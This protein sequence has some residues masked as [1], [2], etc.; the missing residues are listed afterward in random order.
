M[1]TSLNVLWDGE[2]G[3]TGLRGCD[4]RRQAEVEAMRRDKRTAVLLVD[5]LVAEVAALRAERAAA[6]AA[7]AAATAAAVAA[8][9]AGAGVGADYAA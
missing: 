9:V 5:K 7:G 1:L 6:A 8:A 3:R 2:G 4:P